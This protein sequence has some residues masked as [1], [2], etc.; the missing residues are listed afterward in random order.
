MV[1]VARS[2]RTSFRSTLGSC[3]PCGL[4][5]CIAVQT[6]ATYRSPSEMA[7]PL[8]TESLFFVTAESR[9]VMLLLLL[10]LLSAVLHRLMAL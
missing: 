9:S 4:T 8:T 6:C 5:L 3:T 10:S 7:G 2:E 1:Q